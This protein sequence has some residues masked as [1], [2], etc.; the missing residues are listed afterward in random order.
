MAAT[1]GIQWGVGLRRAVVFPLNSDGT[2]KAT[3]TDVYEGLEF[4][5]PRAFDV[6]YPDARLIANPGNDRVRDTIFLPA[7][8]PVKAEL[9]VGYDDQDVLAAL[10]NV[11]KFTIGESTMVPFGTDMQGYE[12]DV[13]LLLFQVAHDENKLTRYHYYMIPR[14]R[15]I[16]M[17]PAFN[18]NPTEV[19]FSVS[20]SPS[21]KHIWNVALTSL[22]EGCTEMAMAD[23]MAEARP[24]IVAWKTDGAETD[25]LVPLDKQAKSI[26]KINLFDATGGTEVTVGITKTTDKISYAV[27]PAADKILIARYEYE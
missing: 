22:V 4:T 17:P 16:P 15:V 20:M 18:D 23:G 1:S 26:A 5:G 19:R 8:D 3:D 9:R 13:A 10:M 11:K 21:T 25:D 24:A 14:A 2:L 7:T 6:T 12:S 27:A